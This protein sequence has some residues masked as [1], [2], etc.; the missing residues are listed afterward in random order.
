MSL[1]HLGDG[2]VGGQMH[3]AKWKTFKGVLWTFQCGLL[4]VLN[5]HSTVR[6]N[7]L[8]VC[9]LKYRN[10]QKRCL[11]FALSHTVENVQENHYILTMLSLLNATRILA[12]VA[13]NK[14]D[15]RVI[16]TSKHLFSSFNSELIG[17][18]SH[19]YLIFWILERKQPE[20][21]HAFKSIHKLTSKIVHSVG[22]NC[23]FCPQRMIRSGYKYLQ[24]IR[25]SLFTKSTGHLNL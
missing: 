20:N 8:G 6:G 3:G 19:N 23:I 11:Y 12:F 7:S 9:C 4:N 25:G 24:P 22:F 15:N 2:R 18:L 5:E 1:V 21:V 16:T 17:L 10:K 13:L 14:D